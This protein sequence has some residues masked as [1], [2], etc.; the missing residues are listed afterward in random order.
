VPFEHSGGLLAVM[1]G[2]EFHV[3]ENCGHIPHYEKPDEV[4]PV[5]LEFLRN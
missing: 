4:N 3:I 5:L 1:P 2:A